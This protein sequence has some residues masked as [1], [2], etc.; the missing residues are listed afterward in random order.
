[1]RNE[2]R[3]RDLSKLIIAG[4]IGLTGLA[5]PG[6]AV[7]QLQ[8]E[9]KINEVCTATMTAC[10]APTTR[11][12]LRRGT[13]EK[14]KIRGPFVDHTQKSGVLSGAPATV[15]VLSVAGYPCS[16]VGCLDIT[17]EVNES[18]NLASRNVNFTVTNFFGTKSLGLFIVRKGEITGFTQTPDPAVWGDTVRVVITGTDIGNTRASVTSSAVLSHLEATGAP[19]FG[20]TRFRVLAN[21]TQ[22]STSSGII[23]GDDDISG[24]PG[25]YRFMIP[26][27]TINYRSA[28][29]APS[30]VSTPGIA[31][32]TLTSPV[33]NQVFTFTTNPL[34][35]A[36]TLRWGGA[37]GQ[38]K[39]T[40]RWV[41]E[42]GPVGGATSSVTTGEGVLFRSYNLN[43]NTTY[44]WRVRAWNCNAPLGPWSA[45]SQFVIQ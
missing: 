18:H 32:P 24:I 25:Q 22:T 45:F 41:V 2:N 23:L 9:L 19:E 8:T 33:N 16:N 10:V 38:F 14:I 44:Q 35:A 13:T 3:T 17:I 5:L 12:A 26:R 29:E 21:G 31:A 20:T 39:P 4:M 36:I 1:M 37:Q 11:A 42:I 40:E 15:K 7:A 30:C 43:R 27:R 34:Q 28:S 6:T